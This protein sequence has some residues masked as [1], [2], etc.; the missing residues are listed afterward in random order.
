MHP[1]RTIEKPNLVDM[2][3]I[4]ISCWAYSLK[5]IITFLGI[6]Y[7]GPPHLPYKSRADSVGTDKLFERR[8]PSSFFFFFLIWMF[9]LACVYL[10]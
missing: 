8:W 3:M 9:V 7:L 1:E 6:I 10:D 5:N 2:M 4:P